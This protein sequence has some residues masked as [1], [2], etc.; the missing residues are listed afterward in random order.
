MSA[1]EMDALA[2]RL[3]N[4]THDPHGDPIPSA[5]GYVVYPED[6]LPLAALQLDTTARITHLEDEPEVVYAQLVAEGLHVGQEVR[7]LEL[8]PQRVRFWG[9]GDEHILAPLVAANISVIPVPGEVP[10]ESLPGR[11]L[12]ILEPGQEG[13]VLSLSSRLRGSERRRLMD[14]GLLPGTTITAELTSAS[15]DPTAYRV[16][17]ALIALRKSQSDL[18]FVE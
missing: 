12:T 3:G 16:R 4:P 10:H 7:L 11:P 5:D 2:A 18:I 6:S 14:L 17:G 9:D 1:E 8:T 15:G 13:K